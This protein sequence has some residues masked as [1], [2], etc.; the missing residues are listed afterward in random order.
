MTISSAIVPYC[1]VAPLPAE[2]WWRWNFDPVVI[3][4][5]AALPVLFHGLNRYRGNQAAGQAAGNAHAV[6]LAAAVLLIAFVSPLCALSSALFS[7]RI[8]HHLLLIAVAAP[9]IALAFPKMRPAGSAAM[10]AA[11][12]VHT[13]TVWVWHAPTPYAFALASH[14][15]YWLMEIT[16]LGSG[17][18]LWRGILSS[19][20]SSA[21]VGPAL[22][23]L[24]GSIIK[25]GL[26]GALL[27]FAKYPLY[28][29]HFLTTE[30]YGLSALDDQQLAG[31]IM[32]VPAALPYLAAAIFIVVGMLRASGGA[33]SA[34]SGATR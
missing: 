16:L 20:L 7:A 13:L 15:A 23:A 28:S 21:A 14:S 34:G 17:V 3:A 5:I 31:L 1:G 27:T 11:L 22:A 10:S 26:L 33:W 2:L 30:P 25:M 6:H 18:V 8:V 12:L 29:A 4:A 24:L 9:L 19:R 32:W